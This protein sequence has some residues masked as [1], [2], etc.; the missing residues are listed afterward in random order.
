ML[1]KREDG[2]ADL[3]QSNVGSGCMLFVGCLAA[4]ARAGSGL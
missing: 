4:Y 1:Y 2:S 3:P